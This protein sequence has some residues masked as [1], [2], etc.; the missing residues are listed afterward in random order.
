MLSTISNFNYQQIV[1]FAIQS[2]YF[3]ILTTYFVRQALIAVCGHLIVTG[4]LLAVAIG[5]A[6]GVVIGG[7]MLC[8]LTMYMKRYSTMLMSD[9]A[10]RYLI[11][12]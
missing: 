9:T 3:Q 7:I 4:V 1:N 8:L 11:S 5:V 6:M 2:Y 12:K 10:F